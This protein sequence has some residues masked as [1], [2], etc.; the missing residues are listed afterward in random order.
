VSRVCCVRGPVKQP[1][2]E[3]MSN[4]G[5][6]TG[7]HAARQEERRRMQRFLNR[8]LGMRYKDVPS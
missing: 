7:K 3:C 1:R 2:G 6:K 5:N 4:Y 8:T